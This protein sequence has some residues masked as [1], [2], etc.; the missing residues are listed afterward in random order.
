MK[1]KLYNFLDKRRRLINFLLIVGFC[2]YL[3]IP[4]ALGTKVASIFYSPVVFASLFL[5][6][7][8]QA[9]EHEKARQHFIDMRDSSSPHWDGQLRS[10]RDIEPRLKLLKARIEKDQQ[11]IERIL[12]FYP[13]YNN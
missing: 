8:D 5:I 11:E 3:F 4:D 12:T 1:T 7:E 10:A 6:W 9:K 13:H 2:I